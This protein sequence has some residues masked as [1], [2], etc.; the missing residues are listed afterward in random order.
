MEE[1]VAVYREQRDV[2]LASCIMPRE[3]EENLLMIASLSIFS[4]MMCFLVI[5]G[6]RNSITMVLF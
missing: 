3:A 1:A 6:Q 4:S 5:R 2:F